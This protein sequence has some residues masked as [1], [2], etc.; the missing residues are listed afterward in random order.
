MQL[1]FLVEP[2]ISCQIHPDEIEPFLIFANI[3]SIGK[4]NI[5]GT[6]YHTLIS[7]LRNGVAIY[8]DYY[9]DRMYWTDADDGH[10]KTAPLSTGYPII[11][12]VS[13]NL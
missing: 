2:V 1:C 8:Y 10:I 3:D 13:G 7:G 6:G 9:A 4:I 12:L 5:D 11:T